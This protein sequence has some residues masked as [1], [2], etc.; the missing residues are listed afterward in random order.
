MVPRE[1]LAAIEL[2][3]P[4]PDVLRVAATS[5]YSRLP[6]VR[7]STN[8]IVGILH[9]KDVVVHF[10]Q[11]GRTGALAALVRPMLRVPDV[12]PADR[13]LEFLRERR[14]HQAL[15]VDD[16]GAIVG[17]ITLEDVIG[18]LLGSVPDEFK[19]QRLLPLRLSDGRVRLPGDLPLERARLWVESA[20]PTD[21][22]TVGDF[23]VRE[24]GRVPET[25]DRF[26]VWELPVEIE[27]VENGKVSSVIA[28]PPQ[29]DKDKGYEGDEGHEGDQGYEGD[30]GPGE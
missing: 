4:L 30:K 26:E 27:S 29:L 20:W 24:T 22:T 9:T 10:V 6:V 8:D 11:R 3:T 13:L 18:E 25:G 12:M 14:S 15:V 2:S 5:P 16:A 1:R 21:R 19:T 23:I 7:R 28:T 17:L